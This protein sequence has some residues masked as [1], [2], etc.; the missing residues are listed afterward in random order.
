[1]QK[2]EDLGTKQEKAL[3][4]H[5]FFPVKNCQIFLKS[6]SQNINRTKFL[7]FTPHCTRTA[8]TTWSIPWLY[9]LHLRQKLPILDSHW[10]F[11]CSDVLSMF[12][13]FIKNMCQKL[14][15]YL[16]VWE[17]HCWLRRRI[18]SPCKKLPKNRPPKNIVYENDS[19]SVT[20]STW[21]SCFFKKK[22]FKYFNSARI[23]P[24]LALKNPIF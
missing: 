1:M 17:F 23:D 10:I 2:K 12:S 8:S 22:T 13:L 14:Y 20:H 24:W 19:L 9:D 21:S 4:V 16:C 5:S 3:T 15:F 7:H 11:R 6:N 18:F